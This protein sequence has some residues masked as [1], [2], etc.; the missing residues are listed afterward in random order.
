MIK[1]LLDANENP[2]W[3]G[4]P[5]KL[6]YVIGQPF[7]YLFALMWGIFDFGFIG[8]FLQAGPKEG[9]GSLGFFIIPFFALHLMPVWIAIGGL[10]Y[11]IYNWKHIN[12]VITEKRIYIESGI[13][14]RDVNIIEFS[15]IYQPAVNVGVIEKLR[16]CGTIR[17]VPAAGRGFLNAA[18]VNI[19]EPYEVYKMIKEMSFDIKSDMNYPNAMRP[20]ENPGYQ[21]NYR[22]K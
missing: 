3:E 13:I 14:G 15:D 7:F 21:T 2:I 20:E 18:L 5:D 19:V 16:N 17:L 4:K 22:S 6:T 10:F 9:F 8:L 11:R 12:Y 1:N